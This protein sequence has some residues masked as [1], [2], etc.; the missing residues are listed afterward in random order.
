M[1]SKVPTAFRLMSL[2]LL[3]VFGLNAASQTANLSGV[4]MDSSQAVVLGASISIERESTGLKQTT[5]S[6]EQG[7]YFFD[8]LRPGS[9]TITA[10]ASGFGIVSRKGVKLDPGQEA[11]LD[12]TLVPATVNEKVTVQGRSSSLQTESAALGTEIDPQ[13][14]QNLPLN[15]RTFQSL[16]ALAPGVVW[17]GTL[18][19]FTGPQAGIFVNGQRETSNYFTV[20]G[21]SANV[22]I[23]NS[24]FFVGAAAGGTFPAATVLGTTHNLVSLDGLQEFKLQTSTYSA[25]NGR[26]GGGQVQIV[27]RSGSNDFHGEVFDYLRNEALDANDWFANFIGVPRSPFRYNDFGGALG[28]P[29]LK[30]RT[31]FYFSYEGLRLLQPHDVDFPV[32]SLSARQAATG[33]VQALL[34]AFPKPNG[35]EDPVSM[36][37]TF[38]GYFP[39]HTSSD[40]TSIR[41]DQVVNQKLIL[42]GRYSEAPSDSDSSGLGTGRTVA[43]LRSA[44]LGVTFLLSPKATSDLRLNYSRNEAGGF[45]LPAK[46]DGAVPPPDSIIFPA[47]FNSSNSLSF[48]QGLG[49]TYILGRMA[50]NLQRQ[51]NLV[52]NTS[53]IQGPHELRFGV[54]YRYLAPHYGTFNYRQRVRFGGVPGALSGTA[55]LAQISSFSPVTV[56]FH[57]LSLHGQDNWKVTPRLTLTYGLRWEL[58][59]APH[60]K[61]DEQLLTLTGFPDIAS[62]QLARP[63]TP[64]YNTTYDNFAPRLGA[65]YQLFQHP[66]REVV[67]RGGFGIFYDLGIGNIGNAALAFPHMLSRTTTGSLP[68]PL[69]PD[70]SAPPLPLSL[71]P[72]Y[73]SATF[74]I[75]LPNHELPR[76]YQWNFTVDQRFGTNQLFSLSYVGEAGRRLLRENAVTDPNPRFVDQSHINLTT[77]GSSADYHAL[78][79]QFQRRMARDLAALLSYTWSHSIDDTSADAGFD[80]FNDPRID[81]GASDFDVRHAFSAALS[82]DIP[83]PAE[84]RALRAVLGNWSMDSI[85]VARTALPALVYINPGDPPLPGLPPQMRPDRVPGVPF[86][87][88]DATL[89][90]GRR[91]NPAAFAVP[92]EPRQGNYGRNSVRGFSLTQWDFDFRR[93]FRITERLNL[94]S[95]VDCFNILN[96][97]NFGLIDSLFGSYGPPFQPNPTFGIASFSAA[98]FGD[99]SPLYAPGGPRSIQLSLRLGF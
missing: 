83:G 36:L 12:F 95:R 66:G 19:S 77:N 38:T 18:N 82:Y 69:S 26:A 70:V 41:V 30:D 10:E 72:P 50:D 89:P 22:G 91:I 4:V 24:P 7:F 28:G 16:I 99:V 93:R 45:I 44:T 31:F 73:T 5:S 52:S 98:Q 2:N 53:V 25:E 43:N 61:G 78:Q 6:S 62:L 92:P 94:Q 76:S 55:T 9:Y 58:N 40:N 59:P 15:G 8:F 88:Q 17:A 33:A 46:T 32:P 23:G 37:A 97:P 75:F 11:R 67:V 85:L 13:F 27:T 29:I 35:P 56:V 49:T 57:N 54:D 21:V 90:G 60:A 74:N 71:D 34:N 96:H 80:N 51:G 48:I 47:P 86:Y 42:F 65:A 63:G 64:L 39:N 1:S 81:R 3:L 84:N 20:D 79:A 87:V 14:V 68:Y